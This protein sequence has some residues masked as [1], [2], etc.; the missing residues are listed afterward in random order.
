MP[1]YSN[2]LLHL[3]L[4]ANLL[5]LPKTMETAAQQQ[6]LNRMLITRLAPTLGLSEADVAQLT[7]EVAQFPGMKVPILGTVLRGV[8]SAGQ[9]LQ[10]VLGA[11]PS[12]PRPDL[13]ALTRIAQMTTKQT[14]GREAAEAYGTGGREAAGRK[15]LERGEFGP[16]GRLL[17]T[18]GEK[19]SENALLYDEGKAKGFTGPALD[20]YVLDQS[21]TRAVARGVAGAQGRQDITV[22]SDP[23]ALAARTMGFD[24]SKAT[25]EAWKALQDQGLELA[26]KI[27]AARKGV[28]VKGVN[29]KAAQASIKVLQRA[30]IA[31]NNLKQRGILT[32]DLVQVGTGVQYAKFMKAWYDGDPDAVFLMSNLRAAVPQLARGAG[33]TRPTVQEEQRLAQT[34]FFGAVPAQTALSLLDNYIN[35]YTSFSGTEPT[36]GAPDDAAIHQELDKAG[37]AR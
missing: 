9:L 34:L 13:G 20:R 15:L 8:G 17:G 31:V 3:A 4:G 26:G 14:V 22:P 32:D 33:E 21:Q 2:E 25:P 27:G 29:E 23:F 35:S 10:G 36:P 1:G 12:A 7:P 37:V 28:G 30:K 11:A 6:Q 24:P 18:S 19:T 16:A 5:A